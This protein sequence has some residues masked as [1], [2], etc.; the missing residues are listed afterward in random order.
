MRGTN[1][2]SVEAIH[3]NSE[4]RRVMEDE[5]PWSSLVG[6]SVFPGRPLLDNAGTGRRAP[7]V[8]QEVHVAASIVEAEPLGE[9]AWRS[10]SQRLPYIT[11]AHNARHTSLP[12]TVQYL[13]YGTILT[14][15]IPQYCT[16]HQ[17]GRCGA[18]HVDRH[19]TF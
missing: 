11:C 4:V 16:V 13:L 15:T 9:G 19:P 12:P 6:V 18:T 8:S 1:S 17:S 3:H 10:R 5:V 7:T 14:G 2:W